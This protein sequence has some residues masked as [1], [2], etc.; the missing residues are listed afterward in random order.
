MALSFLDVIEDRSLSTTTICTELKATV[1][2]CNNHMPIL[3][4][5]MSNDLH[6]ILV[7]GMHILVFI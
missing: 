1:Y 4:L 6:I 2:Y 5:H 7:Y 3:K